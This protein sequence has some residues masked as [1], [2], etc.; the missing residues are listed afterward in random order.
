MSWLLS[1]HIWHWEDYNIGL[2]L[3]YMIETRY[4]NF[5]RFCQPSSPHGMGRLA[6]RKNE[7]I[8]VVVPYLEIQF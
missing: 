8:K 2:E 4:G 6:F 3:V 1:R 5:G 7:T